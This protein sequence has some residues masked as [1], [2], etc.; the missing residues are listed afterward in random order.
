MAF[1]G[2][3]ER[4]WPRAAVARYGCRGRPGSL[5]GGRNGV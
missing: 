4:F 5:H 1:H 2:R 3:I